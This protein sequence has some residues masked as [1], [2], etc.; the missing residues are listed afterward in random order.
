MI[1]TLYLEQFLSLQNLIAHMNMCVL[2]HNAVGHMR[3]HAYVHTRMYAHVHT[4][5]HTHTH[6]H[7]ITVGH[8]PDIYTNFRP[9]SYMAGMSVMPV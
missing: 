5:V 8:S 2:T 7:T 6:A 3:T 4:H 9:I 1:I